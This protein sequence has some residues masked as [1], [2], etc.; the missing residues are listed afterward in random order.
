[1]TITPEKAEVHSMTTKDSHPHEEGIVLLLDT[2]AQAHILNDKKADTMKEKYTRL[3]TKLGSSG[4]SE[5]AAKIIYS[6]L[7]S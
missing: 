3:R 2:A 6:E 5:N 4:A 7:K 1:M